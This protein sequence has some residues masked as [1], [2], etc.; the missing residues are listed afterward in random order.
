MPLQAKIVVGVGAMR[1]GFEEIG[2]AEQQEFGEVSATVVIPHAV[3]SDR[4][5]Y[6][7]LF[8]GVFSP[9]G[10]SQPFHVT[11]PDGL[12][13]R[14]GVIAAASGRCV[15]LAD[16][17][18]ISYGLSG[19]VGRARAGEEV[20]VEGRY[21]EATTCGDGGTIEVVRLTRAGA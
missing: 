17:D 2:D 7:I 10:I 4:P 5:V 11:S 19:D 13:Q 1:H 15:T 9:I 18:D 8:N 16:Q 20:V 21:S 3:P 14:T 12:V 6:L